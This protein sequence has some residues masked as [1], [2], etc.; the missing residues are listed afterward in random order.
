L[1]DL[2]R[3]DGAATVRAMSTPQRRQS[4]RARARHARLQTIREGT[5]DEVRVA[6]EDLA[7]EGHLEPDIDYDEDTGEERD[8]DLFFWG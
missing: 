5:P 1:L 2:T 3:R 4:A 7:A 6:F 8:P